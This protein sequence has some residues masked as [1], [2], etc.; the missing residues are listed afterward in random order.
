MQLP[1]TIGLHRSH[2]QEAFL[3]ALGLLA[4]LVVLLLPHSVPVRG[5]LLLLVGVL[6]ALAWRRLV[7]PLSAIRLESDGQVRVAVAGSDE[8]HAA[9]LRPG[10]TVHPWLTLLRFELVGGRRCT[11]PVT[12]G[13]ATS[14]DFRRLRVFLRWRAGFSAPAGSPEAPYS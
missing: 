10:A 9:T 8:F 3:I 6:V 7:P 1:I 5:A 4:S 13:T 11:L 12:V 14:E 2:F